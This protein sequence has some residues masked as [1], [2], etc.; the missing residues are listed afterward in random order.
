[1]KAP[2]YVSRCD[3]V[4]YYDTGANQA[5]DYKHYVELKQGYVFT[6]GGPV[7]GYD[8]TTT[9]FF[10]NKAQFELAQIKRNLK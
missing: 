9:L 6:Y 7:D 5:S 10:N 4:A 3:A 8:A 2:Q 1:M